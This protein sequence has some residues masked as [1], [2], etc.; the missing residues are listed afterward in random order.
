[1]RRVK[2]LARNIKRL[3][4]KLRE[5]LE[6]VD[7]AAMDVVAIDTR[8]REQEERDRKRGSRRAGRNPKKPGPTVQSYTVT[9]APDGAVIATLDSMRVTLPPKLKALLDILAAD[10]GES[11]DGLVAWKTVDQIGQLLAERFGRKF[12][13]HTISQLMWR[14]R[15]SFRVVKESTGDLIES[16]PVLGARLRRKRGPPAPVCAG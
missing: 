10:L 16:D 3:Q 6:R 14:L 7:A 5:G 2:N 15:E 12:D 4:A 1:M 9:R 8:L 13:R 11:P